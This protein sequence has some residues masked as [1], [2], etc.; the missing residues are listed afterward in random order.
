[1]RVLVAEDEKML[2]RALCTMLGMNNFIVDAVYD[3]E[4]AV[5]HARSGIYDCI[6]MDLMMPKKDGITAIRE[7][8][9]LG[10]KV[11]ILVLT[12]KS[13][14]DDRVLG[15]DSGA[16]DYLTKPFEAKELIARLRAITRR[17]GDEADNMLILGN[18]KLSRT[19]F[20][21]MTDDGEERLTNKEYQLMEMLMQNSSQILPTE[22]IIEKIWGF[23]C[24]AEI[25]VVWVYVSYLRKKLAK[26]KSNV[27]I[28]ALR[29]T[30]YGLEI[31]E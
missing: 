7:I 26:L 31:K 23:D 9:A 13:E 3:G 19:K 30:G 11:P 2:S 8:R 4:D 25:N 16:D 17:H 24:D 27:K 12:A 6:V 20:T 10:I 28:K 15:L 18:T 14:I 22:R 5:E 21:L 1:M 29:N